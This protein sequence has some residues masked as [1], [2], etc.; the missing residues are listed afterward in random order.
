MPVYVDKARNGLGRM[1]TCHML[2]DSPAELHTMAESI[3]MKRSWYQ[4]PDKASFPHYDVSLSRRAQALK[5][6]AIEIDRKTCAT[7]MR[8]ARCRLILSG[9]TWKSA[10]W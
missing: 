6:G 7:I 10:G 8:E 9:Q 5:L 4:S 3:G 1:I 2:A